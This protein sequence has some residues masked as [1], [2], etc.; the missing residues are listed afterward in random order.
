MEEVGVG[1]GVGVGGMWRCLGRRAAQV[2]VAARSY[3]RDQNT[4][5]MGEDMLGGLVGDVCTFRM[6]RIY[7]AGVFIGG[8][9]VELHS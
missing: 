8:V 7:S 3:M 9:R 2:T 6:L 4:G 1:V 5:S